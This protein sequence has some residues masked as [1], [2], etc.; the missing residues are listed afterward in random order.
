MLPAWGLK[1]QRLLAASLE[2]GIIVSRWLQ[3]WCPQPNIQRCGYQICQEE[4]S[5]GLQVPHGMRD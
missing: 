5:M 4:V 3:S 2:E 1:V